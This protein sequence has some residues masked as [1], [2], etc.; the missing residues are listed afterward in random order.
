MP[1]ILRNSIKINDHITVIKSKTDSNSDYTYYMKIKN[2]SNTIIDIIDPLIQEYISMCSTLFLQGSNINISTNS[3]PSSIHTIYIYNTYNINYVSI[4][5]VLP[6]TVTHLVIDN[7]TSNSSLINYLPNTLLLLCVDWLSFSKYLPHKLLYFKF[8]SCNNINLSHYLP[9]IL[10]EYIYMSTIQ[11]NLYFNNLPIF[12]HTILINYYFNDLNNL[13]PYIKIIKIPHSYSLPLNHLPK[14]IEYVI[15]S[16]NYLFN[17]NLYI[18]NILIN[19]KSIKNIC[20]TF[21]SKYIIN[22]FNLFLNDISCINDNDSICRKR[23]NKGNVIHSCILQNIILVDYNHI[24]FDVLRKYDEYR[25]LSF[26]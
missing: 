18:Y 23:N 13:P 25:V 4:N 17:E 10:K 14:Y 19:N 20:C 26:K 21:N 12:L 22:K 6:N 7:L 16:S 8:Y 24:I 11:F 3:I 5:C 2:H 1:Y 9:P 15:L